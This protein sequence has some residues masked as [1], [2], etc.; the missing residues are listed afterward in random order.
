M[1]N[2]YQTAS[3]VSSSC[4][5]RNT[6][7]A[8]FPHASVPN[9]ICEVHFD[10]AITSGSI[11]ASFSAIIETGSYSLN[12]SNF[13]GCSYQNFLIRVGASGAKFETNT[14]N[15]LHK[16]IKYVSSVSFVGF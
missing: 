16:S 10:K 11:C 15:A 5:C 14:C 9:R 2:Y 1:R 4:F 12:A 6:H 8:Y 7:P 3:L 13:I